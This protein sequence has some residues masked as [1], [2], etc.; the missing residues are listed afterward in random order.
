MYQTQPQPMYNQQPIIMPLMGLSE[1]PM[2]MQCPSCK[3]AIV[4]RINH[5][6][7]LLAWLICGGLCFFG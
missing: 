5:K 6:S 2:Q 3:A 4:T 7:G 1:N